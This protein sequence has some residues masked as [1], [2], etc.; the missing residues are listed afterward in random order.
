MGNGQYAGNVKFKTTDA[1]YGELSKRT[2]R[3][4]PQEGLVGANPPDRSHIG[5]IKP[6]RP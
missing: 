4:M 6:G 3:G 1:V 5:F 2:Q